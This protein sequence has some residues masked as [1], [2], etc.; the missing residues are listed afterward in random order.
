MAARTRTLE[1]LAFLA[2]WERRHGYGASVRD[3]CDGLSMASTSTVEYHLIKLRDR[4]LITWEPGIARSI[5]V[6]DE[7][8]S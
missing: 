2:R 3:I 1:V 7:V 8:P 5:R 6:I 4:Q